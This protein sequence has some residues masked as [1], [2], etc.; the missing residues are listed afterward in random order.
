MKRKIGVI[1]ILVSM[2]SIVG[3]KGATYTGYL[4]GGINYIDENNLNVTNDVMSTISPF[5]V[6]PNTTYTISFPGTGMIGETLFLNLVGSITY[7][8]G[9]INDE[10]SCF[11]DQQ[12]SWC[13]FDTTIDEDYLSFTISSLD[14][15]G[16]YNYYG[17]I[18]FQLEE[19]NSS[20]NYVKYIS[21]IEDVVDPIFS[22]VGAY[23][24]SYKTY[25]SIDDI[26]DNHITVQDE[27]DGD[28]SSSIVILSDLYTGNEETVGSYLVELS[29][30]DSSGNI[31]YFSLTV[32]VKDEVLPTVDGPQEIDIS[33]SDTSNINNIIDVNF[34]IHDDSNNTTTNILI[35]DFSNNKSELGTYNVEFEVVDEFLNSI[36]KSFVI[37]VVDIDSP[38]L[39]SGLDIDS[40]LSNPLELDDVL[41]TIEAT[42]NYNDMSF[43]NISVVNNEFYGNEGTPGSYLISFEVSDS[44]LNV[45]LGDM[46]VNVIDDVSPVISGPVSYQGSYDEALELND[47]LGM[48][49]VT[50]N[51][52]LLSNTNFYVLEDT[53]SN[54][55]SIVGEYS[56]IF[57]VTDSNSNETTHSI[58]IVLFDDIAPVIYVDDFIVSVDMNSSFTTDD[59]LSLL[60]NSNELI[61]GKYIVKTLFDGYSGNEKTE[62]TYVYRLEFTN[63]LGDSYEKEFLVKVV[64]NVSSDINSNLLVRNIII[65]AS[66]IIIFGFIVFKNKK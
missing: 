4:P 54:R 7:Y 3:V 2:F 24:K 29:S 46:Y 15:S 59:A 39:I 11:V 27:V 57:G 35:D 5:L 13:T 34:V 10:A 23:I 61:E 18:G 50:D 8:D 25:E 38:V 1:A 30:S 32:I 47:F 56:I 66:T 22:G 26:I 21:P 36:N 17:L 63:E 58:S 16:Y 53:Y 55:S 14:I 33:V 43:L 60:I 31:A 49:S 42:D 12:G 6:K 62:G 52:D 48:L 28:I 9:T 37:N 45:V 41:N 65:Y 20:T 44:S 64:D 40:F 51:V 19:G